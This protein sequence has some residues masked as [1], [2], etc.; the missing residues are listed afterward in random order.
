MNDIKRYDCAGGGIGSYCQ[1]CYHMAEVPDGD[2]VPWDDYDAL[3][4]RLAAAERV[5][6]EALVTL[7]VMLV[8]DM[9][10]NRDLWIK[11]WA[12]VPAL[13]TGVQIDATQVAWIV[14]ESAR[15][16]AIF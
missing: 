8:A 16:V 15:A 3:R 13:T 1:G 6:D 5:R 10:R 14:L 4:S 11:T 2:W 12:K 7:K 9:T